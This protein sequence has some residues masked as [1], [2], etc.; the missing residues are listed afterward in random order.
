[1]MFF[2]LN[3]K[4]ANI[5]KTFYSKLAGN[6]QSFLPN[7]IQKKLRCSN[8]K[9]NP[10]I[11]KFELLCIMEYI[12]DKLLHYLNVSKVPGMDEIPYKFLKHGAEVLI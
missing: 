2:N 11:E 7:L 3:Q 8:K 6:Y 12:A 5:F 10:N 4:N 1:M 9:L